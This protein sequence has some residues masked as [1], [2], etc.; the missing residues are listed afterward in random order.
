MEEILASIRQTISD[1]KESGKSAPADRPS[2]SL[3]S[4]TNGVPRLGTPPVDRAPS[5][6]ASHQSP[7]S[8]QSP[9]SPQSHGSPQS[10]GRLSDALKAVQP[11]P[12]N[13]LEFE[14]SVIF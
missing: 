9:G 5:S 11:A 1:E 12:S 8:A 3:F 14:T 6:S 13:G 10:L 2:P 4:R 7:A